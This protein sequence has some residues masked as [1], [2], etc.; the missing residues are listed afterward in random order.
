MR[1]DA[2]RIGIHIDADFAIV[3]PEPSLRH[4]TN[5]GIGVLITDHN[6]RETL[7]PTDRAYIVYAGEILTEGSPDETTRTSD[8]FTLARSFGC[9]VTT[10]SEKGMR[11]S[12]QM[13]L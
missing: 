2:P 11:G 3:N 6:V 8:G 13:S 4:L 5:R 7:G 9:R 10:V 1:V 12:D